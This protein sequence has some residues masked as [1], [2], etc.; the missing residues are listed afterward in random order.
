MI[1]T[2]A[3]AG[4]ATG[5]HN[6]DD[7]QASG[8]SIDTR[9]LQQ[10]DLFVAL[11]DIRDGHD[12]VAQAFEKGA[13][14]ALVSHIP[15]GVTGPCLVVDDVLEGLCD[16]AR[17]ARRRCKARVIAV[18]GSV[19]KTGTK[20]MLRTA[21]AGQ[22]RVHAAEKSYNNHWGV[23]LTLARMPVDTEY[24][25]IE[26]GMNAPD[27]IAPLAKLT[28]PH[29]AMITTV[30]AV[31][32]AAFD[33]VDDIAREKASIFE[34]LGD[35]GVAVINCDLDT[36][37]ILRDA[38]AQAGATLR[39]F[40]AGQ[41]ADYRSQD[42]NVGLDMTTATATA[43]GQPFIFKLSVPGRHLI[44]NAMGVLA[45]VDA[46]GGDLARA[47]L[48]LADWT[49]PEGRG[50]RWHVVLGPGG[51]DGAVELIDESYNANPAAMA[52][53]LEVFAQTRPQDGIGRVSRG[54]RIAFLGDMLELGEQSEALHVALADLEPMQKVDLV[55]CCGPLMRALHSALPQNKQG[56]WFETSEDMARAVPK[57]V[58]AGDVVM[59][60][61]SLGSK[62]SVV[63]D[64]V[65]KLGEARPI[66]NN[67][68]E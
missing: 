12:F 38:A 42:I 13:A 1:W 63:I 14:A 16:L 45:C 53:T 21:L 22:G 20:D 2:A 3:E 56:Q 37:P 4:A 41:M 6:T 61:G 19:G 55:H 66:N 67:E 27:E 54:R 59:A 65:K 68:V 17:A 48:A 10:G 57:L 32:L 25:V 33:S 29:V 30:A 5:G 11:K 34:G 31:H 7:W 51:I 58:D 60:K 64:A 28:Q 18:T 62:L 36:F 9:T 35:G 40:G 23:P 26:I 47:V 15:E 46:V 52:A 49:P 24:A 44:A 43:N 39:L 8:V 50:Q